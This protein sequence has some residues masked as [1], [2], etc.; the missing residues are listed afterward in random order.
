MELKFGNEEIPLFLRANPHKIS[1]LAYCFAL[2][3]GTE[4]TER[5]VEQAYEWLNGCGEDIQLDE[6]TALWKEEHTLSDEEYKTLAETINTTIFEETQSAG[7]EF[8]ETDVYGFL[9]QVARHGQAQMEEIAATL[10][11]SDRTVKRR[12]RE[13]KG[14][15]L[16]KSSKDGYFFTVKGVRFWKRWI[17]EL[18]AVPN[19]P[20]DPILRRQ[21][22]GGK[23][24]E[25]PTRDTLTP[26][27]G[28][29]RVIGDNSIANVLKQL[30]SG[31]HELP[32]DEW[33][34]GVCYCCLR[35]KEITATFEDHKGENHNL[36]GDCAYLLSEE[37]EK[38]VAKQPEEDPWQGFHCI[39]RFDPATAYK[40]T[41]KSIRELQKSPVATVLTKKDV[42]RIISWYWTKE[43]YNTVWDLLCKE[44]IKII[45]KFQDSEPIRK[46]SKKCENF[47]IVENRPYCNLL[48]SFLQKEGLPCDHFERKQ[49]S[50]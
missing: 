39:G 27:S 18:K 42:D 41:V 49:R 44:K 16:I 23:Q 48:Q 21:G 35:N 26:K 2:F 46:C 17:K 45:E 3:E 22:S 9:E 34:Q 29:N 7:G 38:Q 25:L 47:K 11:V 19:V 30:K 40:K 36:C 28:D 12:A 50:D 32:L 10:R 24:V 37:Q 14:L 33:R 13:M 6:F 5:H 4:P 8:K 31:P 43:S 1:T 15:G 20:V